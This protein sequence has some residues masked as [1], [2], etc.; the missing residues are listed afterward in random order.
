M[1]GQR[2]TNG[3]YRFI[4]FV[5]GLS[6]GLSFFTLTAIQF[7]RLSS[8]GHLVRDIGL[9]AWA[10][11]PYSI[12]FFWQF[13]IDN[14]KL[15]FLTRHFGQR[16]SWGL[17][18]HLGSTSGFVALGTLSADS[19]QYTVLIV[20]LLTSFFA[21]TQDLVTSAYQF[22]FESSIPL[23]RSVT[24]KT[25][26][27]RSGQ[28]FATALLPLLAYRW[29]WAGA[30]LSFVIIKLAGFFILLSLPDPQA[31]SVKIK[32]NRHPPSIKQVAISLFQRPR[33]FL[34]LIA[35]ILLKG[36]E[37]VLG[38][39][40]TAYVGQ[41]GISLQQYGILKNGAGFGFMLGGI[42]LAGQLA[43]R[44]NAF[45]VL[46]LFSFGQ[47]CAAL[48]SLFLRY[49]FSSSTA[50]GIA[51]ASVSIVQEFFQGASTTLLFLCLSLYSDRKVD[52]YHFT[53]L[54]TVGSLGRLM[55]TYLWSYCADLVG[56]TSV[57]MLPICLYIGVF[58]IS[59]KLARNSSFW[60]TFYER[61][62]TR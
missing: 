39:M 3:D 46:L 56:W 54:C 32:E 12:R 59:I 62:T 28:F 48:L 35:V 51:L 52:V 18:A 57:F 19:F 9:F 20:A 45:K 31:K 7:F 29:G 33:I 36:I 50:F 4:M 61:K 38:P 6:G 41:L 24:A 10:S 53:L 1:L 16:K 26:G 60:S 11:C 25:L 43:R 42:F 37:T 27:F 49:N 2:R 58:M 34:L 8:A 15:P 47:S 30:H 14:V 21:A 44:I 55:W 5:F 13:L 17:V 22:S 23:S 40:Q